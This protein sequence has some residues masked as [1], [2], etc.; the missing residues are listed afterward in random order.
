MTS[1]P[2]D[3]A[4]PDLAQAIDREH[5]AAIGAFRATLAHAIRCGELLLKAKAQMDHGQ[6]LPWIKENL[7]LK[8]RQCQGYM[9][10]AQN[11][12]ALNAQATAHLTIDGALALLAES[13]GP[14]TSPF[15]EGDEGNATLTSHLDG[16]MVEGMRLAMA[17]HNMEPI[18]QAIRGD[19]DRKAECVRLWDN[20][21]G[22]TKQ[23]VKTHDN[24]VYRDIRR[25]KSWLR[26]REQWEAQ[27]F[28]RV[29]AAIFGPWPED[30]DELAGDRP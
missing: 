3:L 4:L 19:I 2:Q 22:S 26:H 17:V 16:V 11:Q 18:R 12:E 7:T 1:P 6:W 24:E 30:E 28:G 9:R 29:Y 5:Q 10:L 23:Y 25:W 21:D 15:E 13:N 8:P 27:V 20:A 14:S